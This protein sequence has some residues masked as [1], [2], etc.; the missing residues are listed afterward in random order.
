MCEWEEHYQ[1]TALDNNVKAN[2][3][4]EE[5]DLG[6]VLKSEGPSWVFNIDTALLR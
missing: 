3:D 4:V 2:D 6:R 5:E 1:C